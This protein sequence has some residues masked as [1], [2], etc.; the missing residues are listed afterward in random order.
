VGSLLGSYT[1]VGDI[2]GWVH[3]DDIPSTNKT[4]TAGELDLAFS[5]FSKKYGKDAIVD[6][7]FNVTAL[8]DF[9]SS[10]ATQD[11]TVFGTTNL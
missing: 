6:I 4:L 8:H 1:E 2:A 10:S 3:G 9:T 7:H 11:V 5:G